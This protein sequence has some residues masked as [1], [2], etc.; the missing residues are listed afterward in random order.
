[1]LGAGLRTRNEGRGTKRNEHVPAACCVGGTDTSQTVTKRRVQLNPWPA[2]SS[3]LTE[4]LTPCWG[5]WQGNGR[6][7]G[8][9][10]RH[11]CVDQEQLKERGD[12]GCFRVSG[13]NLGSPRMGTFRGKPGLSLKGGGVRR[14]RY[15]WKPV[16]WGLGRRPA[17]LGNAGSSLPQTRSGETD[18]AKPFRAS[19][20]VLRSLSQEQKKAFYA[21]KQQV[22]C[23]SP[24]FIELEYGGHSRATPSSLLLG[25]AGCGPLALVCGCPQER[26]QQ[27]ETRLVEFAGFRGVRLPP[28]PFQ[29]TTW[30]P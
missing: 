29:A 12:E 10:G 5:F 19:K 1:M 8:A 26:P 27:L 16:L 20:V 21:S 17:S 13:V 2:L 25:A 6:R 30:R 18:R 28:G 11:L 4:E 24:K 7:R 3:K 22:L 14:P 23:P 9:R 15:S